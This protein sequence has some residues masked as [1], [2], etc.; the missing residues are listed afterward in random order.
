[1]L[2][3]TLVSVARARKLSTANYL[4]GKPLIT[5]RLPTLWIIIIPRILVY[6]G[7]LVLTLVSRARALTLTLTLTSSTLILS[8]YR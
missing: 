5:G 2:V 3:L 8:C 6:V 7:R 4:H 1:M